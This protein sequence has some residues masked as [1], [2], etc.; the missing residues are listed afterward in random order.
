MDWCDDDTLD[1][2]GCSADCAS[3]RDG[4]SCVTGT[5]LI[6][7]TCE[8]V[9]G[10]GY[11]TVSEECE[12]Q[13]TDNLDGC[14]SECFIEDGWT[15]ATGTF[16]GK[17]KSTM[18]P[19]CDDGITV[20]HPDEVCDDGPDNFGTGEGCLDDCSGENNGWHCSGGTLTQASTCVEECNDTYITRSEEC[21]D[22]NTD[23]LDGCD[24]T[25][26]LEEGWTHQVT[27]PGDGT[28]LS[29]FTPIC[30]DDRRVSAEV[31]DDGDTADNIGCTADC[32]GMLDGWVCDG[33]D[34]N[35]LDT[36]EGDCGDNFL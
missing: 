26:Q 19:I 33:G 7:A 28:D 5:L 35:T 29:V 10:D 13:N 36:C 8:E 16:N 4:F 27:D 15:E 6:A 21:E 24:S 3:A 22:K 2:Y 20:D 14:N 31:C 34:E 30:G 11:K 23:D 1:D 18:N 32:Q 25:C 9:C 17:Y 12:D